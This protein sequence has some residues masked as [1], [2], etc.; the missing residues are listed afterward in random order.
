M[1]ESLKSSKASIQASVKSTGV[2]NDDKTVLAD[3]T[4]HSKKNKINQTPARAILQNDN[5]KP[6]E[7]NIKNLEGL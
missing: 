3:T 1:R 7:I 4:P 6:D 5:D 2:Y